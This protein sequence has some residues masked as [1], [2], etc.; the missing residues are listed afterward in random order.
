MSDF[1]ELDRSFLTFP[2]FK[3]SHLLCYILYSFFQTFWC[4]VNAWDIK[5]PT[6]G[7]IIPESR[8][9]AFN[10][11]APATIFLNDMSCIFSAIPVIWFSFI[12]CLIFYRISFS[13]NI[14]PLFFSVV[15]TKPNCLFMCS[16]SSYSKK[17]FCL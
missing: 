5:F 11:V 4:V 2:N 1:I 16:L 3:A 13:I 15:D 10:V 6:D 14:K 9:Q 17:I 8:L 12:P 7:L